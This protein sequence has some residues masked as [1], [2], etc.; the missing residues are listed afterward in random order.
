MS[1]L[2]G[3]TMCRFEP[4]VHFVTS[5]RLSPPGLEPP[6]HEGDGIRCA[7]VPRPVAGLWQRE[8]GQ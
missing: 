5:D 6:V 1:D 2:K 4:P 8:G 3:N 7:A